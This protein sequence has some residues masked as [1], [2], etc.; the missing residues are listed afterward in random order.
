MT[1]TRSPALHSRRGFLS[2][3][4]S[5]GLAALAGCGGRAPLV[6]RSAPECEPTDAAWPVVGRTPART[7]HAPDETVP[8][9]PT[10]DRLLRHDGTL[11]PSAPVVG[12]GRL[13]VATT[14]R[15]VAV[16]LTDGAVAWKREPPASWS[17][18]P[19]GG[20]VLAC[21][22]V[23]V[24]GTEGVA[25]FDAADGQRRWRRRSRVRASRLG[26]DSP[27]VADGVVYNPE[28][29]RTVAYDA[30][31]GERLWSGGAGRSVTVDPG[32]GRVYATDDAVTDGTVTALS[33]EGEELWSAPG[34]GHL[35]APVPVADRVYALAEDELLALRAADGAVAWR[36]D[37]PPGR[38]GGVAVADG[39]VYAAAG[40]GELV[41]AHDAA[42]GAPVTVTTD[43]GSEP[44]LERSGYG[45]A[46]PVVAGSTVVLSGANGV[47]A[48]DVATD[49][50]RW[51]IEDVDGGSLGG[52]PSRSPA[53]VDGT[54]Y[55]TG[56]DGVYA[57]R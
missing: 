10:V 37:G 16:D 47:F 40:G 17:F 36:R 38:G 34:R 27:A 49:D 19:D 25:A 1:P 53:V 50:R 12:D 11:P 32:A 46:A 2:A 3:L 23:L 26:V 18:D 7:G 54:V 39:R 31:T 6:G 48:V 20:P 9:D 13:F 33:T 52:T 56:F 21:G 35:G 43:D 24:P 28:G 14:D 29:D 22:R 44:W 51:W 57:L 55:A 41:R 4:G 30:A 15:L 5:G 42:T 8:D 45:T